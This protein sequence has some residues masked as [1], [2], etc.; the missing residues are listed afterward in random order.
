MEGVDVLLRLASAQLLA[1]AA[2]NDY[3]SLAKLVTG[4]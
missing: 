2:A 3:T 1:F 4:A